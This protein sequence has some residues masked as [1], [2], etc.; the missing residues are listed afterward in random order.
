MDMRHAR[1][2]PQHFAMVEFALMGVRRWTSST[3]AKNQL[4]VFFLGQKVGKWPVI[5]VQ[6]SSKRPHIP[7]FKLF[8]HYIC[9]DEGCNQ[10]QTKTKHKIERE[11]ERM[12]AEPMQR[13]YDVRY[14]V[15]P[16]VNMQ[17]RPH[18]AIFFLDYTTSP[19]LLL[20]VCL[21]SLF[22]LC[23]LFT[24][25]KILMPANSHGNDGYTERLLLW[26]RFGYSEISPP[27]LTFA[28]VLSLLCPT[29]IFFYMEPFIV[30]CSLWLSL[31]HYVHPFVTRLRDAFFTFI[32]PP[33]PALEDQASLDDSDSLD[34]LV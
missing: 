29:T 24:S 32:A 25:L 34:S 17:I 21:L 3:A 33:P 23:F 14:L 30:L 1:H 22:L 20:S 5:R 6:I 12:N 27:I 18:L 10:T 26:P 16:I 7:S 8:P 13:H 11:R 28:F 19:H 4:F 15:L 2:P 9:G 31:Y